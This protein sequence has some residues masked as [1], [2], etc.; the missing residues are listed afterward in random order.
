LT[1]DR[2][3]SNS[4]TIDQNHV[5]PVVTF[6]LIALKESTGYFIA[7]RLTERGDF[8]CVGDVGPY[9]ILSHY[10]DGYLNKF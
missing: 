9:S 7:Q 4:L 1:D 5:T 6:D 10:V 2:R 8:L 3:R